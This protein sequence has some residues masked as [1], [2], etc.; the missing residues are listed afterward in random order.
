MGP[1]PKASCSCSARP[2]SA[3]YCRHFEAYEKKIII[4]NIIMKS[5]R[6]LN[7]IPVIFAALGSLNQPSTAFAQDAG[8]E[9]SYTTEIIVNAPKRTARQSHFPLPTTHLKGDELFA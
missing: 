3:Q 1:D 4:R 7:Q 8:G 6:L 2:D 9:Q 5:Q